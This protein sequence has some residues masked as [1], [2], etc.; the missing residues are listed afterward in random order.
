MCC[1]CRVCSVDVMLGPLSSYLCVPASNVAS[2]FDV[3]LLSV[4]C[5]A[6]ALSDKDVHTNFARMVPSDAN[7][8]IVLADMVNLFG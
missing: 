1:G 6:A 7:Q 2:S 3:P 5:S 8:A 4:A